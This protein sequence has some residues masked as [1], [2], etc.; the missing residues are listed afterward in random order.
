LDLFC[1]AGGAGMG[2]HRAGFEVVGVDIK[3]QPR[4]PFPQTVM[5]SDALDVLSSLLAG[6][7]VRFKK[8]GHIYFYGLEDFTAIH[9][10]PPCQRFSAIT[11]MHGQ[12]VVESHVDLIGGVRSLLL[13][14]GKPYVIENVPKAPLINAVMLCGS[15]FGL[16]SDIYHLR[17]H[18]KF[19][20]S[21]D[22]W[23]P[24]SCCHQGLSLSVYGHPGG[25]SCRDHRKFGAAKDWRI[26]MDIDWMTN[27]ELAQAIPPAYTEYIGKWL[28]KVL[29]E[30]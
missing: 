3:P 14:T 24:A 13:S 30:T 27:D 2:Y 20:C 7:L 22:L 15:M 26:G 16:H 23:P 28:M 4:Y 25:N 21:F 8:D 9:A 1:G 10:S 17:R 12:Q 19:E 11:Q 18:R 29:N 6:N 5:G